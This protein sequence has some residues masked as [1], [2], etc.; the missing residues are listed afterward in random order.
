M[1]LS[2]LIRGSI[3]VTEGLRICHHFSLT[4]FG[5]KQLRKTAIQMVLTFK[6]SPKQLARIPDIGKRTHQL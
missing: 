3:S 4:Q 2:F 5:L 1:I 6:L